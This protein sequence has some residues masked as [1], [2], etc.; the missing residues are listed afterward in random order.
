[1]ARR[2]R[3]S[4]YDM[5]D[6]KGVFEKNPANAS[7]DKYT[8]PL[9]FPKMVYHP[10]GEYRVT[11]KAEIIVTPF[12]PE[13]V[14]ELKELI[15]RTVMDQDELDKALDEGWHLHPADSIAAGGGQ[16]PDVAPA[17]AIEDIEAQIR[18]LQAQKARLMPAMAQKPSTKPVLA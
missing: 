6:D 10:K 3:Y 4:I 2:N 12:G 14:G 9:P 16:R 8:G 18:R 13:K 7:S 15:Y 5:M 11:Q 17:G 1:M